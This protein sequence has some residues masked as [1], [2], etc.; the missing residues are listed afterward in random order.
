MHCLKMGWCRM[1]N[2]GS[3]TRTPD[4]LKGRDNQQK[5]VADQSYHTATD[6]EERG[7]AC[8]DS[9]LDRPHQKLV[10]QKKEMICAPVR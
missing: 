3:F 9:Q 6:K 10:T 5:A 4:D 8:C 7:Q 1:G 2:L